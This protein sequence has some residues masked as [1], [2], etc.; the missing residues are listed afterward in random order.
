MDDGIEL[1]GFFPG[2]I[3]INA[4]DA[5][6]FDFSQGMPEVPHTV[7]FLAGRSTPD[8]VVPEPAAGKPASAG[9]PR[10][11]FNPDVAFPQ[12]GEAVDGKGVV[13]SGMSILLQPGSSYVVTFPA[14]GSYDYV[15]LVF[16][17][18]ATGKVVVLDQGAALP[19][20][21]DEYDQA[22]SELQAPL[23]ER[24]LA[25]VRRYDQPSP[26]PTATS[27]NRWEV[28]TGVTDGTVEVAAFVPQRLE[29]KAGDTVS[30]TLERSTLE[31]HTATFS[32]AGAP[33]EL[34]LVEPQP[35]GPP[36]LVLNPELVA[37]TAAPVYRR[38]ELA[39]TGFLSTRFPFP[40]TAELTF[41]EPGE[42][43]YYCAIHGS[44][45][46]RMRGTIVVK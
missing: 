33:P 4:G 37:A 36:R 32:G 26:M 22:T 45:N 20:T 13:S 17:M 27:A 12:G 14:V 46:Q 19:K 39:N 23:I 3:T 5:I 41:D 10:L 24:G 38:G 42:Y 11:M 18:V 43:P 7:S 8:L 21:Q 1:M 2:E 34:V 16:P 28:T 6:F 31:L 44:P 9:S 30:W 25:Q 40:H 29:I 15:D 35:E